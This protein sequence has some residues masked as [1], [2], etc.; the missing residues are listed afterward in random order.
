MKET[1][2][3][4]Q[5]L[6]DSPTVYFRTIWKVRF[7]EIDLAGIVFF[8]RIF[9]ACHDAYI[10]F[11]LEYG[12]HIK[13]EFEKRTYIAPLVHAEADFIKPIHFAEKIRVEIIKIQVTERKVAYGFRL[14][15]EVGEE[16]VAVA[17]TLHVF[18]SGLTFE[19][20]PVPQEVYSLLS[21]L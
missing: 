6:I 21:S 15:R 4:R 12:H 16:V 17:Q 9:E 5:E 11:L 14:K 7:Q 8:A 20:I 18:V 10:Q 3:S 2:F 1:L 19:R 13:E